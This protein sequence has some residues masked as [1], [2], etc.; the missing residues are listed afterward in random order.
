[1][2]ADSKNKKNMNFI[3]KSDYSEII[4]TTIIK[5]NLDYT[6][7]YLNSRKLF[8]TKYNQIRRDNTIK[9]MLINQLE[10]K[11]KSCIEFAQQNVSKNVFI[12]D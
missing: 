7:S 8:N 12:Y 6:E 4:N 10:E 9:K 2:I 3:A 1:M 11:K 5:E